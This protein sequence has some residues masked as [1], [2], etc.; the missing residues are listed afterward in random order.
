MTFLLYKLEN[1]V[2]AK[3]RCSSKKLIIDQTKRE[4][5]GYIYARLQAIIL[6]SEQKYADPA[7]NYKLL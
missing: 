5:Y 7:R 4:K 3:N 1:A 2:S 6:R